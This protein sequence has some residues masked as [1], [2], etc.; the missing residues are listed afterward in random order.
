MRRGEKEIGQLVKNR[1]STLQHSAENQGHCGIMFV[2][3]YS[4]ESS[5]EDREV[6]GALSTV[7]ALSHQLS[8]SSAPCTSFPRTRLLSPAILPSPHP[9]QECTWIPYNL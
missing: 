1:N 7:G 5:L 8:A 2:F 3:P 4:L 6:G 9:G